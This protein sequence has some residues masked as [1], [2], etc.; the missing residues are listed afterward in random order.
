MCIINKFQLIYKSNNFFIHI[1]WVVH[2]LLCTVVRVPL[3]VYTQHWRK[4]VYYYISIINIGNEKMSS[5][6]T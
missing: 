4:W 2:M 1:F 3:I 5:W 6:I